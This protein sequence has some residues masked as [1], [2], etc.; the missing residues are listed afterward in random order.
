MATT[1]SN[2][3]E[4]ACGCQPKGEDY[5]SASSALL[6][7]CEE[8]VTVLLQQ[9]KDT[10]ADC[11]TFHTTE[12]CEQHYDEA[13]QAYC[14]EG[15]FCYGEYRLA[16]IQAGNEADYCSRTQ[17]VRTCA[18]TPCCAGDS[19]SC[20]YDPFSTRCRCVQ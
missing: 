20:Q 6:E 19:W 15:E 10:L 17:N 16:I 13:D 9:A 18:A 4:P 2:T 7:N 5:C 3:G 11:L 14:E 8:Y 12:F 1:D